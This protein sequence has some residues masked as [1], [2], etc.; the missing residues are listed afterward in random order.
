[1]K[2]INYQKLVISGMSLP[3]AM[4]FMLGGSGILYAFYKQL[5]MRN[6]NVNYKI[7]QY[8][9]KL[10]AHSGITYAMANY[11]YRRDFISVSDSINKKVDIDFIYPTYLSVG[12]SIAPYPSKMGKFQVFP[13]KE[14]NADVA[15]INPRAWSEGKAFVKNF[16][17][18]ILIVKD[19][20][21]IELASSSSLSDFLY[22]TNSEKAG[23]APFVFNGYPSY[24]NRREVNFSSGD[25]FNQLW[26]NNEAVCDV[27]IKTNGTFVMSDFGCPV[28]HNTV[29][30]MED[31]DGNIN[32]PDL[33]M[34]N[35]NQVFQGDPALDT[36][37]ATCLPPDGYEEMKYA[38]ENGNGHIL[39]DATTKL[40]WQP[41]YFARDT[42]IMTDV[43]FFTENGGGIKV[44]Q[45]WFLMPPYLNTEFEM[46][47][48][49]SDALNSPGYTC[50]ESNLYQCDKYIE[51]M[52]NFHSK[53]V[54]SNGYDSFVNYIVQGT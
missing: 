51:S 28:F 54:L 12:E 31:E 17:N 20:V 25:S 11:L 41:T 39:L 30:L 6:W 26:P 32:Y 16:Y 37:K 19:T 45:W 14:Y 4:M 50:T 43:E 7:A 52:R 1:M 18:N 8:K 44:K 3:I 36:L 53:N 23:G 47:F 27:A 21:Q 49:F 29:T 35:E 38:I 2:K 13:Y 24:Q 10:N 9:A 33:G 48:V 42:L 15:K 22:L 46:P 34:C 40:N 5:Y